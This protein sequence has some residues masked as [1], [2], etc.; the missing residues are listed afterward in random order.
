MGFMKQLAVAAALGMGTLIGFCLSAQPA[1]AD[2]TVTLDQVGNTVVATGSGTIDTTDLIFL[3]S[4]NNVAR[5]DA[6]A[7]LII[8]GPELLSAVEGI[9]GGP[10]FTG[11]NKFWKRVKH[12]RL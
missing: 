7:G 12:L 6:A 11:P 5:I 2:Y 3:G 10:S 1:Q 9:L 4:D 8:T